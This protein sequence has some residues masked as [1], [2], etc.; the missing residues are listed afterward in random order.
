MYSVDVA[1]VG[2]KDDDFS[3]SHVPVT[4]IVTELLPDG[5]R[6]WAVSQCGQSGVLGDEHYT[7]MVPLWLDNEYVEMAQ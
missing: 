5:P 3:F 2:V 6:S 1:M 4:R 7:D